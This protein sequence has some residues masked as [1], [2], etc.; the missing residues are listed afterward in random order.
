MSLTS[1]KDASGGAA[2]G[3]SRYVRAVGPRLRI[4][5]N[6]VFGLFALLG[7][8]SLYLVAITFLNCPI[9]S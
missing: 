9:I 8:N 2:A 4:L 3:S 1:S 7:A 5:L 6:V